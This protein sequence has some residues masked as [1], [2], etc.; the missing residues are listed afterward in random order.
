[1]NENLTKEGRAEAFA[2]LRK[3]KRQFMALEDFTEFDLEN[4]R[5]AVPPAAAAAFDAETRRY[6]ESV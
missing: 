3:R 4:L 5:A 1:M 2:G 6:K